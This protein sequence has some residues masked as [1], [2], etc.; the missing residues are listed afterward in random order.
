M[1]HFFRGSAAVV[2]SSTARA[3]MAIWDQLA[4]ALTR[5]RDQNV[6]EQAIREFSRNFREVFASFRELFATFGARNGPKTI[7]NDPKRRKMARK[8]CENGA[9]RCEN[10]PKRMRLE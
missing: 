5:V 6:R 4:A 9:K 3:A 8:C 10:G 7:Q 1:L 2:A